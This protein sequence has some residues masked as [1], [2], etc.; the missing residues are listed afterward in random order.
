MSKCYLRIGIVV[1]QLINL[2]M[3]PIIFQNVYSCIHCYNA[4]IYCWENILFQRL[5]SYIVNF[6]SQLLSFLNLDRPVTMVGYHPHLRWGYP[7]H[8]LLCHVSEEGL[9]KETK[10]ENPRYGRTSQYEPPE[11]P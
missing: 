10:A 9:R 4:T 11:T 5:L 3:R 2:E 1:M 7:G 8:F 6:I